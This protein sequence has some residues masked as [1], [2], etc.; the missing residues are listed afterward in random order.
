M[1]RMAEERAWLFAA[2]QAWPGWRGLAAVADDSHV[3]C[4]GYE[5][6]SFGADGRPTAAERLPV[7]NP[8]SA[9]AAAQRGFGV[10][11]AA[12]SPVYA[13]LDGD[14]L[15]WAEIAARMEPGRLE[16]DRRACLEDQ[17]DGFF[18]EVA[19]RVGD[20]RAAAILP[21]VRAASSRDDLRTILGEDAGPVWDAWWRYPDVDPAEKAVLADIDTYGWHGLWIREDEAGPQFTYSIGFYHTLG[22]PE[23]IVV[24]IRHELAHSMLW[25]AYRRVRRGETVVPGRPYDGFL[26]THAVTFV[27]VTGDARREYLGFAQWYYKGDFPA[28]QLVWP[29]ASD[30]RWPWDSESLARLQPL[31]GPVPPAVGSH[32]APGA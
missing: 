18:G 26:E 13:R 27:E 17:Y 15:P 6:L 12:W 11:A 7:D 14:P 21:M 24:G 25:E 4:Q 32:P 2:Q 16:R 30:G 28:L 19:G 20:E 22:V 1:D 3:G 5:L 23:V 9:A 10:D 31:L 8:V 29:S